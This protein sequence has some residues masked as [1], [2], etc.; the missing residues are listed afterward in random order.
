MGRECHNALAN[1]GPFVFV[2][3]GAP[4]GMSYRRRD[5]RL[6]APGAPY[7]H[8]MTVLPIARD[9][10][11]KLRVVTECSGGSPRRLKAAPGAPEV[12]TVLV[13]STT[14]G[15]AWRTISH[16]KPSL[17]AVM[18]SSSSAASAS[19]HATGLIINT[20]TKFDAE[21][22]ESWLLRNGLDDL[23]RLKLADLG[24]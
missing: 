23:H 20:L 14:E 7:A 15:C 3:P 21:S 9:A 8:I 16:G 22:Y 17:P 4:R 11:T 2:G 13:T 12:C 5:V 18:A 24:V 19:R 6:A 1:G 10:G